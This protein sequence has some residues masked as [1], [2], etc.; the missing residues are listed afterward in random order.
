MQ[1]LRALVMVGVVAAGV[2]AS[3]QVPNNL[4]TGITAR[5]GEARTGVG[6]TG[7]IFLE[8]PVGAREVALGGAAAATTT[9]VTAFYWNTAAAADLQHVSGAVSRSDLYGGSGLEH[10][11]AA[12]AFPAFASSIFGVSFSYFTSGDVIVTTERFP[13]GGDPEA[14]GTTSWDGFAAGLHFARRLTDR[15]SVGVAGKYITEGIAMAKANWI[16][17]DVSTLFRTGLYGTTIGASVNN[18][19]SSSRFRGAGIEANVPQNRDVFPVGRDVEV[20]F[21]TMDMP[22]PTSV[23]LAVATEIMGSAEALT[24]GIGEPHGLVL[25]AAFNKANDTAIQ[26]SFG[27]EYR[28]RRLIFAR[29]GKRFFNE[30]NGPWEAQSGLTA[31][32]GL[33]FPIMERRFT[34]D[35]G[36]THYG[37]LP[38]THTLTVQFGY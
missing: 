23:Q 19:G 28:F 14:G 15:L 38:N 33:A 18:L 16:A 27:L 8:I 3:A 24:T 5:P 12:I 7:A 13:E 11:Y 25:N 17:A 22:L 21:R 10:T 37:A 30:A 35:W 31:G 9:G 26:P 34:F 2:P 4:G 36:I 29:A 20:E 6:Q 32:L 1:T